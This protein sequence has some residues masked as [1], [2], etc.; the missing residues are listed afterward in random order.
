MR[1][2]TGAEALWGRRACATRGAVE[3]ESGEGGVGA[4]VRGERDGGRH[5][6][7]KGRR[8]EIRHRGIPRLSR[9]GEFLLAIAGARGGGG[10]RRQRHK[11][12]KEAHVLNQFEIPDDIRTIKVKKAG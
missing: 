6:G 12:E 3:W 1:G 10:H 4:A 11:C 5:E 7:R 8:P 9:T 2:G